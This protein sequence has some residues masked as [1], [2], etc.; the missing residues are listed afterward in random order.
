VK[1]VTVF[2][3]AC[4]LGLRLPAGAETFDGVVVAFAS[5][6]TEVFCIVAVLFC[7][8]GSVLLI[9]WLVMRTNVVQSVAGPTTQSNA[10]QS[11]PKTAPSILFM[12]AS[13]SF[14]QFI[15]LQN[16]LDK[17]RDRCNGG[18]DVTVLIQV[19]SKGL[20]NT[21][22]YLPILRERMY[23]VRT[24]SYIPLIVEEYGTIGFGLNSKHRA[25]A[26]AHLNDFDY[27][28]YA[29]ED[30]LLSVSHLTAFV[31]ATNKLK[32]SNP[33]SWM[34]YQIGFLRSAYHYQDL[35]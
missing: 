1:V 31:S 34:R 25:Y 23:C 12:T 26:A 11:Q 9:S 5:M 27:F 19:S 29:E 33:E 3:F 14:E 15:S 28:S 8:V 32:E 24:S 13:Y 10:E 2:H 4:L 7:T 6:K 22:Q 20:V 16:V 17:W 35:Y 30:M 18:W 21:H